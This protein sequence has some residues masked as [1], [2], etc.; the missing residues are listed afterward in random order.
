MDPVKRTRRQERFMRGDAYLE[1]MYRTRPLFF[2]LL[3][4]GLALL[5]SGIVLFFGGCGSQSLSEKPAIVAPSCDPLPGQI[6]EMKVVYTKAEFEA[7]MHCDWKEVDRLE[8]IDDDKV[9]A[10]KQKEERLARRQDARMKKET[11]CIRRLAPGERPS[12]CWQ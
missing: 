8:K 2:Y 1:T 11:D 4:I 5:V 3:C 7:A 12:Q 9:Q 6:A 10:M